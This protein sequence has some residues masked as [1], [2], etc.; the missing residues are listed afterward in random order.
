MNRKNGF[1]CNEYKA[2]KSG[3]G[4]LDEWGQIEGWD[5]VDGVKEVCIPLQPALEAW[6]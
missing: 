2:P 3:G 4:R 5:W 1:P 6:A